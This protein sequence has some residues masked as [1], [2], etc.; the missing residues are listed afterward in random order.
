MSAIARWCFRHRFAVIAAWALVLVGLGALSQVAKSDYN[1]SFSLPGTGSTTAQQLLTKA[2][3]SQAGDS[4]TIVWQVSHGTVRDAAVAARM[5]G[6][7]EQIAAMPEVA[8]VVSPYG[9]HGAAQVSRDGRTA[10]ATVNFAK[11]ANNLAKADIT[12]VIDAAEA[13]RAPGLNVQL[14][15]Q[16]IEQTE[17]TPLGV[18][19]TVGVLAAAVVLFIAFGSLLAMLLPIVT[20]IAGVGGGLMAITPLTHAMNVVDF[21]PILGALIGLGVGIDYALFIVT[22][23]RRGL[24]SG[25]T[26]EAA[27]VTAID[28]SGRAVL[29]AGSTVCIALLGILVLSVGFLNGLAVASAL[30]VVFTVLAAVTLLP[31]LLGV[32]GMRVLSRR[33][34]RRLAA[35]ASAPGAAGAWARWARTVERRPAVLAAAAAAV[36][37]VLAIPVLSLRLGSSDQG[38]DPSSTTTR[39]AYELLADGFGP[40][41]NGPLLL[42]TQ[43]SSPGDMTA[44]KRLEAELPTVANVT[45]VTPVA[46]ARGVDVIQ[47]TPGTS[48]EAKA[49]SDLIST[50]RSETIPA[51]ERGTTLRVYIGGVTATFADFATVVNAKLPWFILTIVG[52][53]FLLLVVAFRSLL[54]PG[55]AAAMNLLAAA[56]SF[57]VLTAFFQWGWGTDA[58]GLGKAGP[59]EA[60]LPVVTLAI[61]FM[62]YQVF[63]VSRMNEE[64]VHGR[65][66]SDAVRTGHVETARV[67]TAAATIM[68]CV[69]LT[70]SFLG[71]RDVAEFGIGLA[72]AVALDAFILRTVLVPAAMHLFGNANWWLPRWLDRRLPHLAIESPDPAGEPAQPLIAATR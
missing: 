65:R 34:R 62:D 15:G 64:W 8:A 14:G 31:A 23:H 56:A 1:N 36:M 55:T 40:G 59:V 47:V 18:S 57:G 51:A 7:L 30:T 4:D 44:L 32:F 25:L 13:A 52:L 12:R 42:V 22:R 71:S 67:I 26:P 50:L 69:F 66:N 72:A 63:L 5:S 3:P 39:Q 17:Q 6:V 45:N 41:F 21:A 11:Q 37:L 48:S 54:I 19:S 61:L 28:T 9:P 2:I 68:I 49:T 35:A 27:A 60:F 16:A 53:S 43:T 33:Q 29:F 24:Q 58:F 10:Y 46:A 38:N 20:A 70:F